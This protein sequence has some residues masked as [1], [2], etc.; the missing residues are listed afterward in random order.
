MG[1]SVTLRGGAGDMTKAVYDPNLDAKIAAAQLEEDVMKLAIY[2]TISSKIDVLSKYR[3]LT[4]ALFQVN[5]ATGD[6][7]NASNINDNNTAGVSTQGT[8]NQYWEIDLGSLMLVKQFRHFGDAAMTGDGRY[9]IQYIDLD[10]VWVDVKTDIVAESAGAWTA[11]AN[12]DKVVLTSKIRFVVTTLDTLT[13]NRLWEL[14][15]KY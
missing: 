8:L 9:K 11:F 3:R 7:L 13:V 1:I 6:A 4:V 14:E 5:A 15:L 2:D 12:L 10:G